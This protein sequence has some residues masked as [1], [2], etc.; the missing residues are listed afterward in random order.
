MEPPGFGERTQRSCR[1]MKIAEKVAFRE[2]LV[3]KATREVFVV[4]DKTLLLLHEEQKQASDAAPLY[5]R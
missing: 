2:R 1:Q 3:K 4:K 5:E